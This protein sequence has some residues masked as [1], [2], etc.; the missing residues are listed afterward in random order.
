MIPP[1]SNLLLLWVLCFVVYTYVPLKGQSNPFNIEFPFGDRYASAIKQDA[2]GYLW[3]KEGSDVFRYD[4]HNSHYLS[5]GEIFD[6]PN[7]KFETARDL[8]FIGSNLVVAHERKLHLV[9]IYA[10][11]YETIWEIPD[12]LGFNF[13]MQAD[14]KS[15][16][17]FTS[18][19]NRKYRPVYKITPNNEIVYQFDL[20]KAMGDL[21]IDHLIEFRERDNHFYYHGKFADLRIIDRKGN[22]VQLQVPDYQKF[23]NDSKCGTFKLDNKNNLWRLDSNTLELFNEQTR[24]FE[25]HPLTGKLRNSG[26]CRKKSTIK[27]W[28]TT[29]IYIDSKGR[30]WIGREDSFLYCYDPSDGQFYNLRKPIVDILRYGG[31]QLSLVTEDSYGN[32]WVTNQGGVAKVSDKK[33]L[34]KHYAG[35]T[36]DPNHQIY[37]QKGKVGASVDKMLNFFGDRGK[38]KASIGQLQENNKGDIIFG[39]SRLTYK[40]DKETEKLE[41]LPLF[42][43]KEKITLFISPG[44]NFLAT[45]R[46]YYELNEDYSIKRKLPQFVKYCRFFQQKNGDIWIYGTLNDEGQSFFSKLEPSTFEFKENSQERDRSFDFK[47][48]GIR[49]VQEDD[50]GFLWFSYWG[51]ISRYSPKE[52]TILNSI[53]SIVFGNKKTRIQV[54]K[55]ELIG[56]DRLIFTNS[57]YIGEIDRFTGEVIWIKSIKEL[58]INKIVDFIIYG[59]HAFWIFTSHGLVYYDRKENERLLFSEIDG[60]DCKYIDTKKM[61]RDGRIAMGTSNGLFV[62]HPDSLLA[63]TYKDELLKRNIPLHLHAWSF[64]D[65]H[66]DTIIK[67]QILEDHTAPIQLDYNDKMLNL[68]F[69]LMNLQFPD[70]HE[71]SF[72]MEGYEKN[73]STLTNQASVRYT[74]LPSGNYTFKVRG[75]SGKGVWSEQVLEVPIRVAQAW[76]KTWWFTLCWIGAVCFL[77]Y[78]IAKYDFQ[79]KL[80]KRLA[81]EQLR[82]KISSDLHDDVGSILTGLAMQSEIL[83]VSSSEEDKIRL[84][85]INHLS[86][87]AMST[88]RDAV[89]A[90]D[91]RKDNWQSLIDRMHEFATEI[92]ETKNISYSIS[93]E[94]L[95]T[96]EDLDSEIRQNLYLIFK[97][98]IT[99]VVKHSSA[100]NVNIKIEGRKDKFRMV[101]ADNGYVK[102]KEKNGIA[103]LGLSNMK[104]RAIKIDADFKIEEKDGFTIS[105]TKA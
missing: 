73:W 82:T 72:K 22:Q 59:E 74:D 4:G 87:N 35:N 76:F 89:W 25:L 98:A 70:R 39:D 12:S 9:D 5:L 84:S 24:E 64:F 36:N 14:D 79:R 56:A 97:E 100:T 90:M 50:N 88:M 19:N 44:I 69:G 65:G 33:N 27:N 105:L 61:L 54:E 16:W 102:F 63:S 67:H 96:M 101:I 23:K 29:Q 13:L 11:S 81:I 15:I 28:F 32:I 55:F 31:S 83:A 92:L 77:V 71:Y 3:V 7:F 20:Y 41:V 1:K 18:G 6:T 60:L 94:N 8:F 104:L 21:S 57:E 93:P 85:R 2:A 45:W 78:G 38:I 53:D 51:G 75:T 30:V 95:N 62:F 91:N 26:Y 34:F 40:I 58:G 86:R 43:P 68:E 66:A 99:N 49:H 47:N 37:N 10:K 103:G 46:S 42:T 52:N 48:K 17:I 80:E